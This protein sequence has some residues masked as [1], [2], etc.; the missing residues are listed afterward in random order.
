MKESISRSNFINTTTAATAG[1]FL[2]PVPKLFA[3]N[4]NNNDLIIRCFETFG[5]PTTAT[6]DLRF[7]GCRW[8]GSFRPFEIKSLRLNHSTGKIA[9]V[10][11]LE[12]YV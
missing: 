1:V 4:G 3:G 8:E 10:N 11:L 5:T 7:A 6:F 2:A 9:E 12:E